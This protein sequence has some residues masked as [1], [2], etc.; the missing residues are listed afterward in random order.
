MVILSL[1]V[2]LL[3]RLLCSVVLVLVIFGVWSCCW[4]WLRVGRFGCCFRVRLIGRMVCWFVWWVFFRM[5]LS[6]IVWFWSWSI[7]VSGCG[8]CMS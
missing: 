5:L 6:I 3:L 4:S 8:C 1:R 7:V 2:V